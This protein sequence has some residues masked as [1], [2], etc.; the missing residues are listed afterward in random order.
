MDYRDTS[1][2]LTKRSEKCVLIGYTDQGGIAT[3]GW[4]HTGPEV[5][6][7]QSITQ[8]QAN[9]DFVRDQ[10]HAD[11]KMLSHVPPEAFAE[12]SDHQRAALLDFV[13]NTGGGPEL[14]AKNEWNIWR[15]VRELKLADVPG[16]FMRFVYVH[17]NGQ[18][19]TSKGLKNRRTAEV[20]MWNTAD[21][22]AAVAVANAGGDT[23]CSASTRVLPTPPA[24]VA[25]KALART[26]LSVKIATAVSGLGA[27]TAQAIPG[28]QD[29]AQ[30]A[31]DIVAAHGDLPYGGPIAATLT[32]TVV[33]CGVGALFIHDAQQRAA[34]V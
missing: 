21:L 11:A 26:S 5:R 34:R 15:V 29:K 28:L 12:L 10:A 32:A 4:G 18:A 9:I 19:V 25:P 30:R 13:F 1:A 24:P 8:D 31:H 16:E 22:D 7:G 3:W 17:V 6:V 33:L 23:C 27:F 14:G 2:Q 20:V